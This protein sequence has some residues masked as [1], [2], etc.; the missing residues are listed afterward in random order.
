MYVPV[1][2]DICVKIQKLIRYLGYQVGEEP[3][4]RVGRTVSAFVGTGCKILFIIPV[5]PYHTYPVFGIVALYNSLICLDLFIG[6]RRIFCIYTSQ[7]HCE[8]EEVKGLCRCCA[9]QDRQRAGEHSV[10]NSFISAKQNIN[11]RFPLF[12]YT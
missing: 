6:Q 1:K 4:K 12:L 8:N 11:H 10:E 7:I 9:H 3:D 2:K 5:N